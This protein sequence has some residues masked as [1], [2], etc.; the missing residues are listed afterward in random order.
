[1]PILSCH[2]HL[3]DRVHSWGQF[4]QAGR[5]RTLGVEDRQDRLR[6]LGELLR[7]LRKDAGLTGSASAL[8]RDP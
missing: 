4:R 8:W 6:A 2:L 1:M 5:G 7:Q 3:D